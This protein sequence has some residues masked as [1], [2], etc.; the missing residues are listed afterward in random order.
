MR[1]HQLVDGEES[2]K[3]LN[4]SS[5][6]A[7]LSQSLDELLLRDK[8]LNDDL[9][10]YAELASKGLSTATRNQ[11][12]NK[13]PDAAPIVALFR[14]AGLFTDE[15]SQLECD[16]IYVCKTFTLR[17]DPELNEFK[18]YYDFFVRMYHRDLLTRRLCEVALDAVT[19]KQQL[20]PFEAAIS[21]LE[22][23]T[24]KRLNTLLSA[25]DVVMRIKEEFETIDPQHSCLQYC[26]DNMDIM[27]LPGILFCMQDNNLKERYKSWLTPDLLFTA[28]NRRQPIKNIL[29]AFDALHQAGRLIEYDQRACTSESFCLAL[30]TLQKHDMLN[31]Q[32]VDDAAANEHYTQALNVLFANS[33]YLS[34]SSHAFFKGAFR[35]PIQQVIMRELITNPLLCSDIVQYKQHIELMNDPMLTSFEQNCR[36]DLLAMLLTGLPGLKDAVSCPPGLD[37]KSRVA[38]IY[39]IIRKQTDA[40]TITPSMNHQ[41]F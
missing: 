35:K 12:I 28:L 4:S 24:E 3:D 39:A 14:T 23:M 37:V 8:Q 29:A 15:K 9:T 6:T 20:I 7:L 11:E 33:I 13:Y 5:M 41:S 25:T 31:E 1:A 34:T 18:Q 32:T 19:H 30:L 26:I 21:A 10:A 16:L 2:S 27:Q 40:V 38:K 22:P 17:A 36:G